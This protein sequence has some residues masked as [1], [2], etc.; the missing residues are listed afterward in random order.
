MKSPYIYPLYGLAELPQ[1]FARLSA[2]YG[3]TY[4]LDKQIDEIIMENGKFAGVRSGNEIARAKIV[5]GD[6]SYFPNLVKNTGRVVRTIC[7]LGGPVPN[8]KDADSTQII[9]PQKQVNRNSGNY[10]LFIFLLYSIF[11]YYCY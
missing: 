2:I 4:M 6:P 9:I 7:I 10:F 3:G 1:A 11:I 8:T 5:I